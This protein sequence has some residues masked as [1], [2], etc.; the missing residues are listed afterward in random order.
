MHAFGQKW[1]SYIIAAKTTWFT[2]PKEFTIW[3]FTWRLSGPCTREKNQKLYKKET[4]ASINFIKL[5]SHPSCPPIPTTC[6]PK[7]DNASFTRVWKCSK[8]H[9]PGLMGGTGWCC[10]QTKLR[11]GARFCEFCVLWNFGVLQVKVALL[12]MKKCKTDLEG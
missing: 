7:L 5:L 2:K 11:S 12:Y 6:L 8:V 10:Y 9:F 3:C 4:L 1:Q